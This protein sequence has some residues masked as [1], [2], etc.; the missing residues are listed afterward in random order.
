[1]HPTYSLFGLY[2]QVLLFKDHYWE[3]PLG[4][5]KPLYASCMFATLILHKPSLRVFFRKFREPPIRSAG[6][7]VFLESNIR[8][9]SY[10]NARRILFSNLPKPTH[11]L[12]VDLTR[13][14]VPLKL[15]NRLY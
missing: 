1:M 8:V 11:Q 9:D 5:I 3:L 7:E 2:F 15:I 4:M 14:V 13:S 12:R 10:N 6:A